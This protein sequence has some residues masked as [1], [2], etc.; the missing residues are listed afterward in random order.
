M[1]PED[2]QENNAKIKFQNANCKM[3]ARPYAMIFSISSF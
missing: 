1:Q 2:A 3:T